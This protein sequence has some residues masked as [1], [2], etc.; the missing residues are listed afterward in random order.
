M[1]QY[2]KSEQNKTLRIIL[3]AVG[4]LAA[5]VILVVV[6][7]WKMWVLWFDLGAKPNTSFESYLSEQQ[8]WTDDNPYA[9]F[10]D[11]STVNA[12]EEKQYLYK[13]IRSPIF[14]YDDDLLVY[15]VCKYDKNEYAHEIERLSKI[16]KT[17]DESTF[18]LP[19]YVIIG[20]RKNAFSSYA[21]Y[22]EDN[23]RIYY[24]AAQGPMAFKQYSLDIM[25]PIRSN[26]GQPY[27]S[28][29]ASRPSGDRSQMD[30]KR[31]K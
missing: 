26:T 19:A 30:G 6:L 22:E 4:I 31:E 15:V 23:H 5:A 24:V 20:Y 9:I 3:I 12:A 7:P 25:Q 16:A 14:L 21:L 10:P 17:Q 18:A 11:L 1:K 28:E 8:G 29:D 13:R 2:I 27:P